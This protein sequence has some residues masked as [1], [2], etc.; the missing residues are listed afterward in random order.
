MSFRVEQ[1]MRSQ[2]ICNC[3]L[4]IKIAGTFFVFV[5]SFRNFYCL[6][7]S[8]DNSTNIYEGQTLFVLEVRSKRRRERKR[9]LLN[10]SPLSP[11]TEFQPEHYKLW[12]SF[13]SF[14]WGL[15]RFYCVFNLFFSLLSLFSCLFLFL[16]QWSLFIFCLMIEWGDCAWVIYA[17]EKL[18]LAPLWSFNFKNSFLVF[19]KHNKFKNMFEKV[20][21][22]YAQASNWSYFLKLFLKNVTVFGGS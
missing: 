13:A 4:N 18:L 19:I 5:S 14:G 22:T 6:I 1:Q 7:S 9:D 12:E 8:D 21:A 10:D 17:K 16:A 11:F 2:E 15:R 20:V 3:L